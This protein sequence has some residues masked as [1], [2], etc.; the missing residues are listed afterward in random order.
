MRTFGDEEGDDLSVTSDL[1][2]RS[3]M[4]GPYGATNARRGRLR[5]PWEGGPTLCSA[6]DAV[7]R[8]GDTVLALDDPG[9]L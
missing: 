4:I 9:A 2:L 6:R 1:F 7:V 8:V 5:S 3:G